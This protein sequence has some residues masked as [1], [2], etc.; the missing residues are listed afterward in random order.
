[1]NDAG[2]HSKIVVAIVAVD[3]WAECFLLLGYSEY[4]A[5]IDGWAI[6]TG[7]Y[8]IF[9]LLGADYSYCFDVSRHH[10]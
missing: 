6:F 5:V 2:F 1:M 9:R 10:G 4:T 7:N 3:A 8:S